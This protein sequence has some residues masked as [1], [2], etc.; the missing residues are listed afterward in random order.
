MNTNPNR[1]AVY[2]TALSGLSAAIAV[3]VADLDVQSTAGVISGL[4]AIL[5]VALK[6]L[7]GWQ[8]HEAAER[9]DV[10][11]GH[12]PV[13]P[14]ETGTVPT[15]SGGSDEGDDGDNAVDPELLARDF[16]DIGSMIPDEVDSPE[17]TQ[18]V[19]GTL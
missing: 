9:M 13:M 12:I 3:P 10:R 1:V 19:R 5:V 6:W 2:L 8:A 11:L 18:L 15:K 16:D 4:V 17:Q 7:A 14:V